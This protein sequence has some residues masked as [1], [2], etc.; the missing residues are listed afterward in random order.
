MTEDTRTA[1]EGEM[2]S[3]LDIREGD[4][5]KAAWEIHDGKDTATSIEVTEAEPRRGARS[6]GG[7]SVSFCG[8]KCPFF[9]TRH[10]SAAVGGGERRTRSTHPKARHTTRFRA[11]VAPGPWAEGRWYGNC[12]KD[13][14]ASRARER[15][16]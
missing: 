10:L 15:S 7:C 13:R 8:T 1:V 4:E 6:Y 14:M 3:L 11:Y 12:P 2:P 5:V 9:G 16:D